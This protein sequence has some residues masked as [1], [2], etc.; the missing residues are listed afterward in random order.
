[1]NIII[2]AQDDYLNNYVDVRFGRARGFLKYDTETKKI[3][4]HDNSQNLNAV[5]GAGIQTAQNIQD[6]G[7]DVVL[8]GHCGPKAFRVLSLAGIKV[9]T[10]LKEKTCAKALNDYLEGKLT[11]ATSAD[12]EGHWA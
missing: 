11:E 1:M 12:V 9:F 3:T 5:Q 6:L 10:G 8:T 7:A 4:F 2:T